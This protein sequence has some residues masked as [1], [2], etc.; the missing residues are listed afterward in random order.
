MSDESSTR[1]NNALDFLDELDERH[2]FLLDE[3][4]QLSTRIDS[5]LNEYTKS[6]QTAGI[7]GGTVIEQPAQNEALVDDSKATD[8]AAE[9][10]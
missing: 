9:F 7:V 2:D 3:L 6:R 1:R 10:N 4:E 8:E 5:V